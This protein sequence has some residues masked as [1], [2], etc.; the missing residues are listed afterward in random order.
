MLDSTGPA[1]DFSKDQLVL[2]ALWSLYKRACRAFPAADDLT[3]P[4]TCR[5]CCKAVRT[6][7]AL[8]AHFFKTHGRK[9]AYRKVVGGTTCRACRRNFWARTRLAVHLRDSPRCVAVLRAMAPSEQSFPH[10]LGSR[11]W[12][13]A[14]EADYTLATPEQAGGACLRLKM[15]RGRMKCKRR[16]RRCATY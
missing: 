8:G 3:C 7:A 14:A 5:V 1:E 2:L 13:S 15:V 9:A 12:R 6:K 4:W 16:T 11:G 10:G